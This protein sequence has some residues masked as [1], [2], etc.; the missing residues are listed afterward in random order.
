[1]GRVLRSAER[2][3]LGPVQRLLDRVREQA[4]GG[5]TLDHAHCEP[6]DAGGCAPRSF[7]RRLLHAGQTGVDALNRGVRLVDVDL[8]YE[9]ELIVV[10]HAKWRLV[11]RLNLRSSSDGR[12]EEHTSE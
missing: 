11:L 3:L 5:R 7:P 2:P 10:G 8:D 12:S 1:M 6:V 9:F 4:A